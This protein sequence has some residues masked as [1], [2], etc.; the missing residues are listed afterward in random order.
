MKDS[1]NTPPHEPPSKQ[2]K[3]GWQKMLPENTPRIQ[4]VHGLGKEIRERFESLGKLG[5]G[6]QRANFSGNSHLDPLPSSDEGRGNPLTRISGISAWLTDR[7]RVFLSPS[8]GERI[9]VRGWLGGLLSPFLNGSAP[10]GRGRNFSSVGEATPVNE[11]SVRGHWWF[12]LLGGVRVRASFLS[13]LNV[14][15]HGP[16]QLRMTN[17]K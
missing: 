13:P 4:S 16:T 11:I 17:S 8:H 15:G 6:V 5:S 10:P 1:K 12:P 7:D 14:C 9:K 2:A 3:N